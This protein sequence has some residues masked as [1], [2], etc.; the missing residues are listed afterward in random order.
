MIWDSMDQIFATNYISWMIIWLCKLAVP[1]GA[2]FFA[3]VMIQGGH[4]GVTQSELS[5]VFDILVPVFIVSCIFSWTFMGLLDTSIEVC[6]VAFCKL[7]DI[8]DEHPELKVM[9]CV[10]EDISDEFEA[11]R[12]NAEE[13]EAAKKKAAGGG[14]GEGDASDVEVAMEEPKKE[15]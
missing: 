1:V 4:M 11:A 8:D 5:T 13:E 9:L 3:H 10:P 2:T 7:K 15:E 6:L 12:K 14:A